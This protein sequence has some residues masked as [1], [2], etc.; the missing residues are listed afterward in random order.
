MMGSKVKTRF[1]LPSLRAKR[2]EGDTDGIEAAVRRCFELLLARQPDAD[3]LSACVE[4]AKDNGLAIVC[5][6]LINSNEFAFLPC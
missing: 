6:S 3:E 4:V 5:R 1:N 2:A